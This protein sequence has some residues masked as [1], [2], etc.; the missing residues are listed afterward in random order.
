MIGRPL[1]NERLT[2]LPTIRSLP[3]DS[4]TAVSYRQP[5]ELFYRSALRVMIKGGGALIEA[6]SMPRISE[7]E[8][9]EIQV[10]T[11]FMTKRAQECSE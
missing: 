2:H 8:P 11:E 5:H 7:W 6:S 3:V 4:P 1:P 9:M 10:V